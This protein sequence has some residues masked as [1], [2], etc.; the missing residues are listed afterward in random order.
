M[1]RFVWM[2]VVALV[3]WIFGAEAWKVAQKAMKPQTIAHPEF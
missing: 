1:A 3:V 2:L